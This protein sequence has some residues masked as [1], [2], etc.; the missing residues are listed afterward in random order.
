ML[1]QVTLSGQD[2]AIV[3]GYHTAADVRRWQARRT[4]ATWQLRADLRTADAFHL[5]QQGLKFAAPRVGGYFC[6]PIVT[7]PQVVGD[8]LT[9]ILGPIE[10]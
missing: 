9:A 1:E 5:R 3:W 7:A 10:S 6:W 8:R 2:A 4:G